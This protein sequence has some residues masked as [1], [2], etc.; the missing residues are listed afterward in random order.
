VINV[1]M[2]FV[3]YARILHLLKEAALYAK[4]NVYIV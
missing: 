1:D 3:G 4:V 2:E